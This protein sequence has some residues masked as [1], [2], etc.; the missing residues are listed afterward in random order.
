MLSDKELTNWVSNLSSERKK[1]L[2]S[3]MRNRGSY[4]Y[5]FTV[6]DAVYFWLDIDDLDWMDMNW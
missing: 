3:I 6:G 2:A 5:S 1:N 4:P